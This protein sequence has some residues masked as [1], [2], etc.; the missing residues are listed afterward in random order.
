M[1][2]GKPLTGTSGFITSA[3]LLIL[4]L[5]TPARAEMLG[6]GVTGKAGT[7]GLGADV[8][9]P[10]IR[11]WVNVRGGYN[12]LTFIT[13]RLDQLCG[14]DYN[15]KLQFKDAPLLVDLHPLRGDLRLT[16]GAYWLGHEASLTAIPVESTITV[17][18]L[19]YTATEAGELRADIQHGRNFGPYVGIGWG[20]AAKDYF[21]D[22]PVAIGLSLDVGVIYVGE[23]NVSLRQV[24]GDVAI[25]RAELDAEAAQL[26]D[27]LNATPYY[28]IVTL[29]VHIRF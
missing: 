9:V 27:D 14:I 5:S 23:S 3:I 7:T 18:G 10:L 20:N 24:G 26:E 19:T 13:T 17:G 22:L 29:G 4:A 28:P 16:G 15:A 21:T 12:Y 25:P 6:V 11:N 1:T 2:K 8:T